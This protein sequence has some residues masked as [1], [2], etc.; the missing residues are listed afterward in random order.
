M[1]VYDFIRERWPREAQRIISA[2]YEEDKR[3]AEII[4]SS[5]V[6]HN[7]GWPDAVLASLF[8]WNNTPEGH[9]YWKG[10]AEAGGDKT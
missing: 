4:L 3:G 1:T 7:N 8:I 2:T 5:D 10:V 9:D 6:R